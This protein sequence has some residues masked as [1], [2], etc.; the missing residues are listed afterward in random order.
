MATSL[1]V[2]GVAALAVTLGR[3]LAGRGFDSSS[4]EETSTSE[5]TSTSAPQ[6]PAAAKS[7][8]REPNYTIVDQFRDNKIK[9]APVKRG[10]PGAPTVDRPLPPGGQDAGDRAPEWS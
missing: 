5:K 2:G 6:T 4:S 8:A 1:R 3:T 10:A 7:T 9:D